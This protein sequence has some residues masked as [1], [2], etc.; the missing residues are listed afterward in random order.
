MSGIY[1]YP[2]KE[3]VS[4][5]LYAQYNGYRMVH[6]YSTLVLEQVLG[7]ED[8]DEYFRRIYVSIYMCKIVLRLA[9]YL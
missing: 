7:I 2:A 9:L 4:P 1:P 5:E 3:A 8:P 6:D